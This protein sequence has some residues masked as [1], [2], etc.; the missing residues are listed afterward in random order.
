MPRCAEIAELN[1]A[2]RWQRR[3]RWNFQ[4]RRRLQI[5]DTADYKSALRFGGEASRRR[6]DFV[7][8]PVPSARPRVN[9]LEF[10][11][12]L[13]LDYFTAGTDVSK[14]TMSNM[15]PFRFVALRRQEIEMRPFNLPIEMR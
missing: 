10:T 8:G 11:L 14:P 4:T 3:V 6:I 15:P 1:S 12:F 13:L 7:N 9:V 2:D 5:G